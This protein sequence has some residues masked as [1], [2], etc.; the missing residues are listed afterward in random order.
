MRSDPS[1]YQFSAYLTVIGSSVSIS[2]TS[3]TQGET[4]RATWSGFSGNVNVQVYKGN[5]WWTDSVIDVAG[6]GYQDLD[7]TGWEPRS[8]YRV[9]VELRSD[10]SIYRFSNYLSVS[11]PS[12]S[13]SD[14]SVTQG[15]TVRATWSGFTGNVNVQVFKGNNWW[16]DSVIDVAGSGYQDLDTTGWEPRSDYRVKVEL[17]S[18]PS[19]YRFSVYLTVS[20][21]SFSLSG[22]VTLYGTGLPA[23]TMLLS[24]DMADSTSTGSGGSYVLEN[25]PDGLYTVTPNLAGYSFN[26]ASRPITVSGTSVA[27]LDF[28]ACQS[29]IPLTGVV[30]DATT[31]QALSNITVTIDASVSDVT[32]GSGNYEISGLSCG[33]HQVSVAVP[34]GYS[35]Y[36]HTV[37]IS[38]YQTRDINLTKPPTVYGGDTP[39]G[40]GSDPVNTA[41]GNYIY[42]KKDLQ[43]SGRGLPFLFERH[44]NSQSG[45]DGPLGY[46]WGHTYYVTLTE[47]PDSNVTI[48]WGDG[49]TETWSP[50]GGGGFDPQYGVFDDLID[51]GDGTYTLRKKDQTEYHFDTSG[52]LSNIVDRNGNTIGLTYTGSDLTQITD[53]VGRN[54]DLTHDA[55]GHI[56]QAADPIGRT[57]Q[58][59][60]DA[61]GDIAS[62]TDMNGNI[63]AY[64]YDAD[65]QMLTV[66]DPRGNTVVTNVYDAVKRV[67]NSQSDAKGGFTTYVYNEVDNKTTLTDPLG[68]TYYHYHDEL[69]RLIQEEDALG[70]S[71]HYSYDSAGNRIQVTDKNGNAKTYTYDSRGNVLTKTDALGHV[72]TITYDLN[73]NPL[74]RTD[75]LGNVASYVY[76]VNGNLT[77]ATDHLGNS[78]TTIYNSYGQPLTGTDKRGNTTTLDYDTEGNL[79]EV[80]DALGNLRTYTYDG[81]GRRLTSTDAL[82]RTTTYTYDA[83]DNFLT[84]TD[85][86]GNVTTHT[87]DG[88]DNRLTAA[89][90]LGHTTTYAYDVKDLLE[91]STDALGNTTGYS[92]DGLD[93]RISS[94]DKSGNVTTYSYDPV[95]NLI[96][97]TDA[98]GNVT[99]YAYDANGNR[100]TVTDPLGNSA[101]YTYDA[102]DRVVSATGPLGNT[103]TTTYDALGRT[104]SSTNAKGQTTGFVHDALGRLT[105]VTDAESG[106]VVYVYDEN[107]N[108]LST[109]DPNGNATI[110]FYDA[111]NRMTQKT[112]A[113]G[114]THQYAFNA[115][116]NMASQ[117]DAK[118]NTINYAYDDA[119]RLITIT[120]PDASTVAFTYDANGNRLGMVD[121]LG[122][123]TYSYD[124]LNRLVSNTDAFGKAVAYGYDANGNR[125]SLAYPDAKAVTYSYD[126]LNRLVTVN[127]WVPN[128][129]A[130]TYDAAGRL[131]DTSN[132]NGTTAAYTYDAAS[133]LTGLLNAKS[134]SSV[135]TDY[136]F[137]LDE[138]GNHLQADKDEPVS[139]SLAPAAVAY[140]YDA[141][142]RMTSAG[143]VTHTYDANGNL[144]ARG[145]DSFLYDYK[146]R[147]ILSNIAS[148]PTDYS[149]DG[150]GNRLA[151]DDDGTITKYI[152]DIKGKVT[153]V[154][155][156][157][158]NAGTIT[159]YYVYGL[160]LISKILPDDTT[161]CYHYDSRGSTAALT[162]AGENI[163]DAYAYT[164]FGS[165]SNSAGSTPNSFKHLG[166]HGVIDEGN[167]LS[168][169]RAR[170][171]S[172]EVGRF[173]TKDPVTGKDG[174]SQ[175]LN[176]YIY[177]LNNPIILI[178]ISGYSPQEG[179]VSQNNSATSDTLH[180]MLT[181]LASMET[182]ADLKDS[183]EFLSELSPEMLEQLIKAASADALK[184][185]LAWGSG[186]GGAIARGVD[187]ASFFGEHVKYMRYAE[188]AGDIITLINLTGNLREEFGEIGIALGDLTTLEGWAKSTSAITAASWNT[189]TGI[190]N[191]AITRCSDGEFD[192]SVSGQEIYEFAQDPV[193]N[194]KAYSKKAWEAWSNLGSNLKWAFGWED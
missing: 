158:D 71:A 126:A 137:T 173:I 156:E 92:Y 175:S 127:D 64:T 151:K 113:L 170:Y 30:R 33:N 8:D 13:I 12:V 134:D 186:Q 24:G 78:T 117:T 154:L 115:A 40:Y 51:N 81:A 106:T 125:I 146:D 5:N 169:I 73:N 104:I 39:S 22:T 139:P 75:A 19:T 91:T 114:N 145:S 11:A 76:D 36:T 188:Y 107:G 119:D 149:Y 31:G 46:G 123:S 171:Y 6:S 34:A 120:Y 180:E 16:T 62:A 130:Y 131:T 95:G 45:E 68:N 124:A 38:K 58:F 190:F 53:T 110:Y 23:V 111:L 9:K 99:G 174:D 133:R 98:L 70:N 59:A 18:D 83:N 129:T 103:G 181:E 66:V 74:T 21:S 2:D 44:Y 172:P 164:S 32:D 97:R 79:D 136:T 192:I 17:R 10:P 168:Y 118:G 135:I 121:G 162:D 150:F 155:A 179:G 14:T 163:T 194:T 85:P 187:Q 93:R 112:E 4:V 80:T 176:R 84:A 89:D 72:T 1:T 178:D 49:K 90:P 42:S 116:G 167:G 52:R 165:L 87:Y 48:K 183:L 148:V 101:T 153:N 109:V 61:S 41:T 102:L 141:E 82:G 3:V 57:V 161:I 55:S 143:G 60:Y 132:P 166:R 27:G 160:G 157:T 142:N 50:D 7:T 86:L 108:R 96:S 140:T 122:T 152:L 189:A 37:D 35:S 28:K 43:L 26:L 20:G 63:T 128:T 56:T 69:L 177:A 25:I 147:L 182:R 159:A 138:L 88:N 29:S 67:V 15:E 100:L 191:T 184:T 77:T 185:Q 54:V 94:T 65:H 144:T 193:E 47:D 105:G